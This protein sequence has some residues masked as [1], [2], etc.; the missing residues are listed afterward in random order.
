VT[1]TQYFRVQ[2]K[3][4]HLVSAW[5]IIVWCKAEKKTIMIWYRLGLNTLAGAYLVRGRP[6]VSRDACKSWRLF[7]P[8]VFRLGSEI[9]GRTE[10]EH[11][12]RSTFYQCTCSTVSFV[13]HWIAGHLNKIYLPRTRFAPCIM[14]NAKPVYSNNTVQIFAPK[15]LW[16]RF[17]WHSPLINYHKISHL[18][19]RQIIYQNECEHNK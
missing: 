8:P 4:P 17:P 13:V 2:V 5:V 19:I 3:W 10:R 15:Q 6:F 16:I 11:K 9:N 14:H 1:G 18:C 7:A 12:L